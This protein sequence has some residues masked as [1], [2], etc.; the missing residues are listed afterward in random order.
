MACV[1][2][3]S[4]RFAWRPGLHLEAGSF[5]VSDSLAGFTKLPKRTAAD[6]DDVCTGVGREHQPGPRFHPF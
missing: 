3:N 1:E 5:T 6:L 4:R 2:S